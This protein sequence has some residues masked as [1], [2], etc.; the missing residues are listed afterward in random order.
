V[1]AM[2]GASFFRE[3]VIRSHHRP[4][5]LTLSKQSLLKT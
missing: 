1:E 3:G 5:T 4:Q 2:T